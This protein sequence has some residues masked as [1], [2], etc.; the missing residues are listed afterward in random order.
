[1]KKGETTLPDKQRIEV[2][3]GKPAAAFSADF[4]I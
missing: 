4:I 3:S 1:M 2:I